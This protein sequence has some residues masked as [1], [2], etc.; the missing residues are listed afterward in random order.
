MLANRPDDHALFAQLGHQ[1]VETAKL[2]IT[3]EDHAHPVRLRL[4]DG[5]LESSEAAA[6]V[7][8]ALERLGSL[9]LERLIERADSAIKAVFIAWLSCPLGYRPSGGLSAEASLSS[10]DAKAKLFLLP[11]GL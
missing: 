1:Q 10:A 7:A 6:Y 5:T 8:F 2:E 4:V 9:M 3:A 11:A